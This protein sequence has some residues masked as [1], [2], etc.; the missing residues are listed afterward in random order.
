M[1][2]PQRSGDIGWTPFGEL[3]KHPSAAAADGAEAASEGKHGSGSGAARDGGSASAVSAILSTLA[4]TARLQ[5]IQYSK[6]A[7]S[8]EQFVRLRRRISRTNKS[9]G[10]VLFGDALLRDDE[11]CRLSREK[12]PQIEAIVVTAASAQVLD[13]P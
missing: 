8:V 3:L 7:C 10:S 1:R 12:R 9:K 4:S 2:R 13:G 6:A 5:R 11:C